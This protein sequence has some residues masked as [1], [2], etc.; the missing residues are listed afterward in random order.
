MQYCFTCR[1]KP[2]DGR[3]GLERIKFG[4]MHGVCS[5]DLCRV[6][7]RQVSHRFLQ[8]DQPMFSLMLEFSTVRHSDILKQHSIPGSAAFAALRT[9]S[10]DHVVTV[11][12]W[13]QL[14]LHHAIEAPSS[15]IRL[16][17]TSNENQAVTTAAGLTLGES[18]ESTR[19]L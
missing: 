14:S 12:D 3:K 19:N 6:A 13:V 9:C 10:V 17:N 4:P 18:T 15:G 7:D 16:I 2:V 11:P 5:D 1:C 8:S